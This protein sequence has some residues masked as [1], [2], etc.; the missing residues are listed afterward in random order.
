MHFDKVALVHHCVYASLRVC[1]CLFVW[2][3][4]PTLYLFCCQCVF[5]NV[6]LKLKILTSIAN[7]RCM[8]RVCVCESYR[9]ACQWIAKLAKELNSKQLP[10]AP[11]PK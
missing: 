8:M 2:P 9:N 10:V 5:L 7:N 11:A 6:R 3:T 4:T 1:V